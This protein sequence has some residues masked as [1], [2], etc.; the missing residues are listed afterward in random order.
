MS[1]RMNSPV[2]EADRVTKKFGAFTAVDAVSLRAEAGEILGFLGPNGAGKTTLLKMMRGLL[3][4]TSG[5]IRIGGSDLS[6]R[7]EAAR[8][9]GYMSQKFSLYPLLTG[10]ENIE[11]IGGISDLSSGEIRRK[12]EDIRT[13]VPDGILRQKTKDIPPGFKQSIALFTCLMADPGI[14]LLDEPT[15]GVG[16]DIR[17]GFWREID[18]LKKAGRTIL[19]TTHNL[20]DAERA[21]RLVI[22]DRG[23]IVLDGRP[24]DLVRRPD[25]RTMD[26]VY[27]EAVGHAPRA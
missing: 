7:P 19:L 13:K 15:T 18:A 10:F 5:R 16:P 6:M 17:S 14:I 9:L 4:P 25:G 3:R 27:Q 20:K 2:L 11:L 8:L 24:A 21:D 12:K 22:I 26:I 1:D 23:R